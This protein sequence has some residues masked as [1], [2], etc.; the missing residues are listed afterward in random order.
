[1]IHSSSRSWDRRLGAD[2]QAARPNLV[3]RRNKNPAEALRDVPPR[4]F[5]RARNALAARLAKNG[6]TAEN[7]GRSTPHTVSSQEAPDPDYFRS[8][9]EGW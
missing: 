9:R 5:V 3:A 1:M 8:G 7:R 4:K 6:K 2:L